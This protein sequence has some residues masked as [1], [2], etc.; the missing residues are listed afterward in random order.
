MTESAHRMHTE[1]IVTDFLDWMLYDTDYLVCRKNEGKKIIPIHESLSE[2]KD[3]YLAFCDIK[4]L[5][6]QVVD[7]IDS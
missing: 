4:G 1:K 7:S 6:D 2:I 3:Q 5:P